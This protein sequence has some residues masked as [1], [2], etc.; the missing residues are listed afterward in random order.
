MPHMYGD[1][2]C[3]NVNSHWW[4]SLC[5]H[6]KPYWCSCWCPETETSSIYWVQ[7]SV[8][9]LRTE[10][11]SSLR[12]VVFYIKDKTMSRIVIVK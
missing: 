7:L 1:S 11:V 10:T 12:N 9:Y 4:F 5:S 6:Y 8:L 3:R 2:L